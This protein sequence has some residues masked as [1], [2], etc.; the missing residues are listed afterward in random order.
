MR[1]SVRIGAVVENLRGSM[2]FMP[3]VGALAAIALGGWLSR[4]EVTEGSLLASLVFS[5]GAEGARGMLQAVATAVITVTSL[6][7]SLTVVTLQLASTQFSPRL[8]RTFLRLPANQVVLSTFIATFV[9]SIVVLRTVRSAEPP[10][11]PQLAVTVGFVLVL[12]SVAALV[13]FIN[14]ITTEIRVDTLMWRVETDTI[15]TIGRV[16]PAPFDR[17]ATVATLPERP[18]HAVPIPAL[19]AG[20]VQAVDVDRLRGVAAGADSTLLLACHVGDRVVHNGTLAWLWT[21]A[22]DDPVGNLEA[23]ARAVNQA[24][25]IGHERTMQQDISYGVRQLADIAVKAMSPGVN[26]PT[27]AVDAVGHLTSVLSVLVGRHVEPLVVSDGGGHVRVAVD[28]IPFERHL[29]RA[30]AQIRRYAAA[31]PDVLLALL[32]LCHEV[33]QATV[34]PGDASVIAEHVQLIVDAA[35]RSVEDPADLRTV[36]VAASRVK[37]TL[38]GARPQELHGGM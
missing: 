8:L 16:H 29:D 13:F 2:W 18:L 4:V 12:M 10:Y 33:G 11:V 5:G 14:H 25:T 20:T 3:G 24:V 9:Y 28:R 1:S 34:A 7:F 19:R 32:D 6:V 36:E 26:D 23:C 30:I 31:E 22:A 37:A 38:A 35:R 17:T 27:T 15:E 21:P